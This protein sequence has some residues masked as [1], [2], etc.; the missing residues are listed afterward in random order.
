[1][2][3]AAR[4]AGR[5]AAASSPAALR[6]NVT[7]STWRGSIA[8]S[9]TCH[10]MRRVRTRVLPEPAP[11]EDR[12]R[13]WQARDRVALGLVETG[14]QLDPCARVSV[15][16]CTVPK[17]Y[18][19]YVHG[20][21]KPGR[22]R[23]RDRGRKRGRKRGRPRVVIAAS[24]LRAPRGTS[25]GHS[26]FPRIAPVPAC[27]APKDNASCSSMTL[28]PGL[29]RGVGLDRGHR[30]PH[31][32]GGGP[33]PLGHRTGSSAPVFPRLPLAERLRHQVR[34]C[35]SQHRTDTRANSRANSPPRPGHAGAPREPRRAT[36]AAVSSRA[37]R[38]PRT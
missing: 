24:Q 34:A 28:S 16:W 6:V 13:A 22:K 18:D 36:R 26:P 4:R 9:R 19:G 37:W 25:F 1:M 5:G 10:A 15:I 27:V 8:P 11:R 17:G 14:E 35:R 29:P 12:E 20:R 21:R 31:S 7:A 30:L 23:G 38:T 3:V 33:A 32:G 2:T